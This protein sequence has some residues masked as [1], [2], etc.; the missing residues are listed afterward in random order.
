MCRMWVASHVSVKAPCDC[1]AW[2]SLRE[3]SLLIADI[4]LDPPT[5]LSKVIIHLTQGIG[6][7]HCLVFKMASIDKA[8]LV[9]FGC[10]V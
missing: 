4:T 8:W 9:L 6:Q 7:V 5:M 10:V 1:F 2:I 3:E